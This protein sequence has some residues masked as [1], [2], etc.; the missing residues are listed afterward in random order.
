MLVA[1][2]SAGTINTVVSDDVNDWPVVDTYTT[3]KASVQLY[4]WDNTTLTPY[5]DVS[6]DLKVDAGRNKIK[7]DAKVSIPIFGSINAQVLVDLTGGFALE[8][9]PFLGVCQHTALNVTLN[10]TDILTKIYSPQGGITAYD[11]ESAAPWDATK[12][13]KFTSSFPAGNKT[14]AADTYFD[15]ASHDGKWIYS[16]STGF[17]IKVPGGE[18]QATF[19]DSDFVISGCNEVIFDPSKKLKIFF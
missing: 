5:K 18:N 4:T 7:A 14:A 19:T 3:F 12:M 1:L 16:T 17:V 13:W 8:Y 9:V 2:A 11:G 10:M 6:A 15:E